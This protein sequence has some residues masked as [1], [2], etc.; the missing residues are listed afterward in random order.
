MKKKIDFSFLPNFDRK[1]SV[2]F[3]PIDI[4][5]VSSKKNNFFIFL[6]K[7]L[8]LPETREYTHQRMQTIVLI[9]TLFVFKYILK[10][11]QI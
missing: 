4:E 5:P 10:R 8:F 2:E 3:A 1:T 9:F 7:L 6:F 11:R